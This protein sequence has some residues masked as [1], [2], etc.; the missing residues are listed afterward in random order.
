MG[1]ALA[2][3]TDC[4][5][6]S[7][8]GRAVCSVPDVGPW[9]YALCNES[10]PY[11]AD[12]AAWCKA[13]GGTWGGTYNGCSNTTVTLSE[14][15]IELLAQQFNQYR[16][17]T[18][19]SIQSTNW[20]I[21]STSNW[22]WSGGTQSQNNIEVRDLRQF[23][24]SCTSGGQTVTGL[25]T[26]QLSCPPGTTARTVNGQSMC[27][28]PIPKD[29]NC[30]KGNPITP[31][32]GQKIQVEFDGEFGGFA[33]KRAY[34]SYGS[35]FADGT[36]LQTQSF[37]VRW[38]DAF[39]YRLQPITGK[40]VIAALSPPN[41]SI[42]YFRAD[43]NAV[44]GNE[45][46]SYSLATTASGYDVF[47]D[48]M[49]LRFDSAGRLI[50]LSYAAGRTYTLTYSDGSTS[51]A[52]G[53]QAKDADGNS[54]GAP[55]PANQ[56]IRVQSQTGRVLAYDRDVA[57]RITQMRVGAGT[58]IRYFY[59]V[60][61][62][63]EKVVYP[64]G[65][66]RL[67]HYNEPGLTAGANLQYALTGI[68]DVDSAGAPVRYASFSYDGSGRATATE[69]VGGA[70]RYEIQFDPN[71]AQA[72]VVDPLGTLRTT[73]YVTV[74]GV[75]KPTATSQPAGSGSVAAAT[76]STYDAYGNLASFDDQ[77]G[78]RTCTTFDASRGLETSRVEGLPQ[79]QACSDVIASGAALP[80][81][82]RKVST[83]WHPI[84]A[85]RTRVAEPGKITTYIYNGQPDPL[86]GNATASCAPSGALLPNGTPLAVL[87]R[88]VE[89][90]TNDGNGSQAFAATLKSGTAA[91]ENR[92]TYNASGQVLTHD[93]PRTDVSDVTSYTYYT[94]SSADHTIGDL[95]SITNAVGHVTQFTMYDAG[96]R[97]KRSVSPS[98]L[99]SE[100][101]YT[102]RGWVSALS[103]SAGS[104]AAQT[105]TYVY[106]YDGNL[107]SVALPDGT[108]LGYGYDAARRLTSITD[109]AGNKVTYVL[110]AA[111]NR[112]SEQ[113]SNPSGALEREIQRSYDALGR[114]M[115]VSGVA[116]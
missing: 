72:A 85:L 45:M 65:Q 21:S 38:R 32:T 25:K 63:V 33:L 49:L 100:I 105:T 115:T 71:T 69:H 23:Y 22:C 83:Q 101:A 59:S 18:S 110:D 99:V 70:N 103:L 78:A 54:L 40:T 84:W 112:V 81:G 3:E 89:Q 15:N 102:P 87:C 61:D 106:A 56:L 92:W 88:Q 109:A 4:I 5:G 35:M 29:C 9:G 93:G 48:G 96:G 46:S 113:Y 76:A 58:P 1:N 55:V 79:T 10:A 116:Q 51:G 111:G 13:Y 86:N 14:S 107:A 53:Q 17:N 20:N 90:A 34:A 57:G 64:G 43:G 95:Q 19:C 37:G 60:N 12:D 98:G 91:R 108:T 97:L 67:Y 6:E 114:L 44:L 11:A 7:A 82:T 77:S 66:T 94:D 75:M 47:G 30:G 73:S 2:A 74:L 41:G 27:V 8:D 42:Q 39:D 52:S 104:S 31:E 50:S 26:R 24:P 36:A 68:S 80:A 28:H 62:L 16:F